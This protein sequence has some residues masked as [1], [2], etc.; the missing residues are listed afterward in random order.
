MLDFI[1][2]NAGMVGLLFFV[3]VFAVIAF[4][5]L[6]PANKQTIESYKYIPLSEDD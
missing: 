6:R 2:N 4:W 1:S 5:A 3:S